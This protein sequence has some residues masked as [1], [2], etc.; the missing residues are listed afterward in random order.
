MICGVQYK[1]KNTGPPVKKLLRI[2]RLE[3]RTLNCSYRFGVQAL[4]NC[5]GCM[6][7]KV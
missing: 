5:E 2:P 6:L 4:G 3:R 7:V 1:L